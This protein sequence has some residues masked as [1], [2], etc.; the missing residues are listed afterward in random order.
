MSIDGEFE[1][2]WITTCRGDV[3]VGYD[4][5]QRYGSVLFYP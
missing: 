4:I 3:L 2:R 1:Q 5:V